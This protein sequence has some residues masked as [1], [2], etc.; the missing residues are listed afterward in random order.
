[1]QKNQEYNSIFIIVCYIIKYVL[2]IFTC[3]NIIAMNLAKLFFKHIKCCFGTPQEVVSD[4]DS[5]ITSQFWCEICEIQMIKR[6]LFIIYYLQT[7][8]QSKVLNHIVKDYLHAYSS[9]DQTV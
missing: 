7:D 9:E 2:F 5:H 8:E 4:R 1:M 3:E 6:C